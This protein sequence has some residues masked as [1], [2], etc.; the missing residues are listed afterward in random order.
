MID[1][2]T[3]VLL[4]RGVRPQNVLFDAFVPTGGTTAAPSQ[5]R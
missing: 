1:A 2:A 4:A 3:A 5:R